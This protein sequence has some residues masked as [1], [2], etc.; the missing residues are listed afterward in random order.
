[1]KHLTIALSIII[2]LSISPYNTFAQQ[3][4]EKNKSQNISQ[5]K[6]VNKNT[7]QKQSN[8]NKEYKKKE[9]QVNSAKKDAESEIES[10]KKEQSKV[11]KIGNDQSVTV[12]GKQVKE[13][14]KKIS[15]DKTQQEGHAYG[16]EKGDVSG[17]EVGQAR[18]T[19]AKRRV[20]NTQKE[21]KASQSKLKQAEG[22][23][24]YIR[25]KTQQA[26]DEKKISEEAYNAKMAKIEAY[27]KQ[28]RDLEDENKN[29]SKEINL[30]IEEEEASIDEA[31]KQKKIS[32]EEY[33]AKKNDLEEL[34]TER[35]NQVKVQP[36]PLPPSKKNK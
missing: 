27:E 3:D 10:A 22:K 4:V 24:N 14:P 2:C 33:K 23:I 11:V 25:N 8:T 26:Y 16:K 32:E 31:Y 21:I 29:I 30:K 35:N 28:L 15:E 13:E 34:K 1:M 19:E 20:E 7:Q 36:K 5:S 18:S 6:E 17:R 9:Q 12:S